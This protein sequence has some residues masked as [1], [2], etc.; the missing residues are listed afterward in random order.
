MCNLFA[1]LD[2]VNTCQRAVS[3]LMIPER[4][5]H[6][7]NRDQLACLLGFLD[8]QRQQIVERLRQHV[9]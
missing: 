3:D 5:L 4:D 8:E 2:R 7:V 1:E 6:V 9:E